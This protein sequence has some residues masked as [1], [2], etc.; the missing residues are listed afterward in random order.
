MNYIKSNKLRD[1]IRTTLLAASMAATPFALADNSQYDS[2][3]QL[4]DAWLD[5][6]VET[7]LLVNR[8]L[9][10]FDIDT[11]VENTQVTLTGTVNSDVD[12]D[13][14]GEIAKGIEG[15]HKV[16]NNLNVDEP[17]TA[18]YHAAYG[19]NY[20]ENDLDD[21]DI[22]DDVDDNIDRTFSTWYNDATTTA[23]IKSEMLWNDDISGLEIDVDTLYGNVT[24]DGEVDTQAEKELAENIA[25][26]TDGVMNVDNQLTVI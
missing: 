6:K 17:E 8:H 16:D 3:N 10:N 2:D 15:V 22:D 14:A 9:N 12:K 7:A 26:N 20:D 21:D 18:D 4:K 11:D 1:A 13:L 23:E 5:G 25:Q 19:Y 24:L